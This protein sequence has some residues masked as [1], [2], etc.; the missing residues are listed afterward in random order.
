MSKSYYLS[1][2]ITGGPRIC[3][4]VASSIT[5]LIKGLFNLDLV[6]LINVGSKFYFPPLISVNDYNKTHL[7][8]IFFMY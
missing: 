3:T 1:I 5:T 8:M 7:K 6:Q 4:E 2:S